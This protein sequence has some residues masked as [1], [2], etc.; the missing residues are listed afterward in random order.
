MSFL[1]ALVK[2]RV[3]V[4][5]RIWGINSSLT[6]PPSPSPII[7]GVIETLCCCSWPWA[8]KF[9]QNQSEYEVVRMWDKSQTNFTAQC[10]F[11]NPNFWNGF[12]CGRPENWCVWWANANIFL[13][14]L[15]QTNILGI[16]FCFKQKT[17]EEHILGISIKK[18][19]DLF[20]SKLINDVC[21]WFVNVKFHLGNVSA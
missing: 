13:S 8:Q 12:V 2:V 10:N 17:W 3:I 9:T 5:L 15:C 4:G 14:Y 11:A 16:D 18:S 1:I 20:S 19:S 21:L 7:F 6:H